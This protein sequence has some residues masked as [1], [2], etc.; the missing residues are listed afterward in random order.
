ME[1]LETNRRDSGVRLGTKR[2]APK[3]SN[4]SK[5]RSIPSPQILCT[6]HRFAKASPWG[7][8]SWLLVF[9]LFDFSSEMQQN[10]EE[11][12][13][14]PNIT[15]GCKSPTPLPH[16]FAILFLFHFCFPMASPS[17]YAEGEIKKKQSESAA[18]LAP[19]R[20]MRG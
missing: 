5:P 13:Q 1:T 20:R 9:L 15:Q 7:L 16:K 12:Q 18:H 3:A 2:T 11:A 10:F 4:K 17:F 14:A 8:Q 6:K 19:G